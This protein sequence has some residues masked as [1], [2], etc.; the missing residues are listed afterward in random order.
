MLEFSKVLISTNQNQA[1]L[2][3][4]ISTV[5]TSINQIRASPLMKY[6]KI[7]T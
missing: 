3:V 7:L 5:S 1:L 6:L 2:I 4:E